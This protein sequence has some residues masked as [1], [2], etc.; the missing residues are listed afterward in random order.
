M[1]RYVNMLDNND[2]NARNNDNRNELSVS[3]GDFIDIDK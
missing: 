3:V 1:N 2:Q